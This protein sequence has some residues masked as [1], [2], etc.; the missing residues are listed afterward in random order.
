MRHPEAFLLPSAHAVVT[1]DAL[2][3]GHPLSRNTGVVQ[4]L[5]P[6]FHSRPD[7]VREA[8]GCLTDVDASLILP[9]HRPALR[10]RLA[11]AVVEVTGAAGNLD[12]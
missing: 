11:D 10:M 3:T 2:V 12:K 6:M 9:G 8:L 4:M 1:G 5:H 7:E